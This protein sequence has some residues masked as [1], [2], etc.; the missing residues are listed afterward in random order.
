MASPFTYILFPATIDNTTIHDKK[1]NK[2]PVK[3]KTPQVNKY[4]ANIVANVCNISHSQLPIPY[5]K[6]DRI[7]INIPE[8]E[9]KLGLAACKHNLHG[10]ILWPKGSW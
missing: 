9:Y 6:G 1:T 10:R 7:T 3:N 4:F 2:T 8:Q 5:I